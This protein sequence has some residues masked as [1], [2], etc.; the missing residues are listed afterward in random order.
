MA[1]DEAKTLVCNL[2]RWKLRTISSFHLKRR[3]RANPWH[4]FYA[5]QQQHEASSAA[6]RLTTKP[7]FVRLSRHSTASISLQ[8]RDAY[9]N[10][11][12]AHAGFLITRCFLSWRPMDLHQGWRGYSNAGR[13]SPTM[14]LYVGKLA[15]WR[16]H[17]PPEG[18]VRT[19]KNY[20]GSSPQQCLLCFS[21]M[22]TKYFICISDLI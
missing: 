3:S 7:Q 9:E 14:S 4:S 18:S 15:F 16:R 19:L 13:K 21:S 5:E 1:V 11:Q 2:S 10:R 22:D 8:V 20:Q 17:D 6:L 12:H